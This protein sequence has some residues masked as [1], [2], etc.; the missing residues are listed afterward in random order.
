MPFLVV[1]TVIIVISH[2]PK[3]ANRSTSCLLATLD[4]FWRGNL[5]FIYCDLLGKSWFSDYKH[6]LILLICT[7]CISAN[8]FRLFSIL[9]WIWKLW[10]IQIVDANFIFLPNKLNFYCRNYSIA[11]TIMRK[12]EVSLI[13]TKERFTF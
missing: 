8:S 3:V 5:M 12:Y 1:V 7:Y 11:E 4:C 2:W 6:A 9:C 13:R 10:K